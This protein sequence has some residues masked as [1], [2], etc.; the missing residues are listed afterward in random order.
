[1]GAVMGRS[2]KIHPR[3]LDPS[4]VLSG[5]V[6]PSARELVSLIHDANPSGRDL[7]EREARRRYSTKSRLQSL[8][9]RRFPDE[10]EVADTRDGS[11]I[12]VLTHRPTGLDA[13]HALVEELDEDA[14][15][16]VRRIQDLERSEGQ[17]AREQHPVR[18]GRAPGRR[19]H[20]EGDALA[21][22][23]AALEAFDFERAR[24][25]LTHALRVGEDRAGA[26]VALLDL[27]VDHL[28]DDAAALELRDVLTAEALCEPQVRLLMGIAAAR[29]GDRAR[30]VEMLDALTNP[31]AAEAHAHLA[32]HSL[33]AGDLEN[34]RRDLD[35]CRELDR[36]R[37]EIEGL[38][39]TLDDAR[40]R[41][42]QALETR[43]RE[44]LT[45]SRD[46]EALRAV[47]E[48]LRQSP[49][50]SS[51]KSL[52]AE[53]EK[54]RTLARYR[55]LV[56]RATRA[57][58]LGDPAGAL[59]LAREAVAL[60]APGTEG[61]RMGRWAADLEAEVRTLRDEER[62]ET[63]LGML[64]REPGERAY[65][66]YLG[67]RAELRDAIRARRTSRAL[68]W[69]EELAGQRGPARH[70]A[71]A[72][73]VDALVSADRIAEHSPRAALD[74]LAPHTHLLANL[75]DYREVQRRA[76]KG[77]SI[78]RVEQ[79]EAQLRQAS[80]ALEDGDHETVLDLLSESMIR[81]LPVTHEQAARA[82]LDVASKA[83]AARRRLRA[84]EQRAKD[85]M[86]FE[87]L[88]LAQRMA[89]TA[90]GAELA[91]IQA[92]QR[93]IRERL[94]RA[95][96]VQS[97][98]TE[99]P[100]GAAPELVIGPRPKA[101][102]AL[103]SDGRTI[104]VPIPRGEWLFLA[105]ADLSRRVYTRRLVLR[106]PEP[107]SQGAYSICDDELV[108]IGLDGG[109][110]RVSL[111]TLEP[112]SWGR[113]PL[114]PAARLPDFVSS[115]Q[116]IMRG[117]LPPVRVMLVAPGHR[118]LWIWEAEAS[119]PRVRVIDL[120]TLRSV[121]D[122]PD[123]VVDF[124]MQ[125]LSE[126]VSP[127]MVVTKRL[128][129]GRTWV[130]LHSP[131]GERRMEI[132]LDAAEAQIGAHPGGFGMVALERFDAGD[133][134]VTSPLRWRIRALETDRTLFEMRDREVRYRPWFMETD[135]A[136]RT[137]YV[138][139]ASDAPDMSLV[140]LRSR[141]S[142]DL[143]Q[144]YRVEI[145]IQC[146]L[147]RP[148][149][150][151]K[152]SALVARDD[153]LWHV[154]LDTDAPGLPVSSLP[155]PGRI[156]VHFGLDHACEVPTGALYVQAAAISSRMRSS[157]PGTCDVEIREAFARGDA[158]TLMT[159]AV[160]FKLAGLNAQEGDL[161]RELRREHA[162]HPL[163]RVAHAH[164]TATLG[165]WTEVLEWTSGVEA[166]SLD[167]S[168]ARHLCHLQGLAH[169]HL[170][171]R[172]EARG[173]LAKASLY[174][175]RCHLLWLEA[176]ATPLDNEQRV[177]GANRGPWP[178][179][180][181]T[182]RAVLRSVREADEQLARGDAR[183][184]FAALDTVAVWQ[185][186]EV[187][188]LARLSHAVL[189]LDGRGEGGDRMRTALV[190]ASFVHRHADRSLQHRKELPLLDGRWDAV[191][192]DALAARCEAWMD[193][194]CS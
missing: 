41:G 16:L 115:V 36:S 168:L 11:E 43:A 167:E 161:L 142:G 127:T 186:G 183:A 149:A 108:L 1:M 179:E 147:C 105:L 8:L 107:L 87:G 37:P 163:V 74:R 181:E 32:R 173:A 192:L 81:D 80:R 50:S 69:L 157:P 29:R 10:I 57:H 38:A 138:V 101:S 39:R 132:E 194:K 65:S 158:D 3:E 135:R 92:V 130:G 77:A 125:A 23:Q 129:A 42:L 4:D 193:A 75:A 33:E 100:M 159:Y 35:R 111:D 52:L 180:I 114:L 178:R 150:A 59:A 72:A 182:V 70:A 86:P 18:S 121:R 47:R 21:Q 151:G 113:A 51:G 120:I 139:E 73:A 45:L 145:P 117:A 6:R 78:R 152:V 2:R 56:A 99:A 34:A 156:P 136:A 25:R 104:V 176:I 146:M 30:A 91:G 131:D 137:L 71:V 64:E 169:L 96:R 14:R 184:A 66:A 143:V 53:L 7:P 44:L 54:R 89:S 191:R 174:D 13:C 162:R 49:G 20:D 27:L 133:S 170:G 164:V 123:L 95:F 17:H 55:D 46:E 124:D 154:D 160:A 22:G 97:S 98:F 155:V 62:M 140:A 190:L 177:L 19:S 102:G 189:L 26:A 94:R 128:Q 76:E 148:V 12:V 68:G 103:L 88:A 61:G 126:T 82:L 48:L 28:A 15:S 9:I 40:A 116:R 187:Q 188:S 84:L 79:A 83:M 85:P 31:R 122:L 110:L 166:D 112:R 175:G 58:A 93:D 60:E 171:H 185:L 153:G 63:V 144:R 118:Y 119:S 165:K 141:D 172:D 5:R 67:C 90:H 106:L 109:V 134:H 24:E